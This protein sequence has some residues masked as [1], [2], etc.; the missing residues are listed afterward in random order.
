MPYMVQLS[1][2]AGNPPADSDGTAMGIGIMFG[3]LPA[4]LYAWIGKWLHYWY[5][6]F[7]LKRSPEEDIVINKK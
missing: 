4:L 5:W 7:V 2:K 6:T 1:E 3:W